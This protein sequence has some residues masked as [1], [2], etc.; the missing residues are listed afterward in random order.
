MRVALAFVFV[1]SLVGSSLSAQQPLGPS[2]SVGM[3]AGIAGAS[4]GSGTASS[5]KAAGVVVTA[6]V[7]F[8]VAPLVA[9]GAQA[10]Y[11]R[12]TAVNALF[13]TGVVTVH[14]PG[15]PLSV[16][17]G[18]GFGRGDFG[19]AALS[20]LAGQLGA[21]YEIAGFGPAKARLFANGFLAS[22]SP[23]NV[24]LIDAGVSLGWR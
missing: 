18:G 19:G 24:L 5:D 14:L 11:W 17:A 10:D 7:D 15:T 13:M 12:R 2:L 3:G 23:Q 8:P 20:G 9:I 22:G 4:G 6:A 16:K 1:S 21:L